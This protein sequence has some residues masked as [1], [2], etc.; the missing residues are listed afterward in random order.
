MPPKAKPP[1]PAAPAEPGIPAKP[2]V[3]VS[4]APAIDQSKLAAATSKDNAENAA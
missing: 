2:E 1:A 4:V 3:K